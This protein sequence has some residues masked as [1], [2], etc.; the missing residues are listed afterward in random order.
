M[1]STTNEA[2]D[3]SENIMVTLIVDFESLERCFTAY[4][5]CSGSLKSSVRICIFICNQ[6]SQNW[7]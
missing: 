5:I 7:H 1:L 6:K 4:R 2:F 3:F